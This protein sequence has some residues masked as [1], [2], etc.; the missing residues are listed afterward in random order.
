MTTELDQDGGGL[1]TIETVSVKSGQFIVMVDAHWHKCDDVNMPLSRKVTRIGIALVDFEYDKGVGAEN[2]E[3]V[4]FT[5]RQ[6]YQDRRPSLD[7]TQKW[8]NNWLNGIQQYQGPERRAA[9]V[10]AL[11]EPL[12]RFEK[13]Y[14]K[15]AADNEKLLELEGSGLL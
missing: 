6:H 1:A 5:V 10:G 14:K 3:V 15:Y 13:E 11:K 2:R 7:Y 12:K 9:V 4:S 8:L